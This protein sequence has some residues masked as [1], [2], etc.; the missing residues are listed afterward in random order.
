MCR[1]Y[2]SDESH[3]DGRGDCDPQ[4]NFC[5]TFPTSANLHRIQRDG[6]P[7]LLIDSGSDVP[8]IGTESLP[9]SA[10]PEEGGQSLTCNTMAGELMT[11]KV[12]RLSFTIKGHRAG[13]PQEPATL[14]LSSRFHVIQGRSEV[15]LPGAF[16]ADSHL[17]GSYQMASKCKG[18]W[19]GSLGGVEF[20][21]TRIGN[22]GVTSIKWTRPSGTTTSPK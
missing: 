16:F 6:R 3:D 21:Q 12:V 8:V 22:H 10:T 4:N 2:E 18:G 20:G 7:K 17:G 5:I 11:D 14:Q 9:D 15:I 19:K 1:S 13:N